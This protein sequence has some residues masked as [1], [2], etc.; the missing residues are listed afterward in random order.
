MLLR[1]ISSKKMSKLTHG[2]NPQTVKAESYSM[3]LTSFL[4]Q[5]GKLGKILL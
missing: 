3:L 4:D 2:V 1:N 5:S